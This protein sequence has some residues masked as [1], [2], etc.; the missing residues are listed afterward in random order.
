MDAT[1]VYA[2][3]EEFVVNEL[4]RLKGNGDENK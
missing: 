1:K 2:T 3:L 4:K